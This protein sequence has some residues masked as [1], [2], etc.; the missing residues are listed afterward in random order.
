M[1]AGPDTLDTGQWL[2]SVGTA[3]A[4][5]EVGPIAVVKYLVS[6][7]MEQTFARER[8]FAVHPLLENPTGARIVWRDQPEP[9]KLFFFSAAVRDRFVACFAVADLLDL[10]PPPMQVLLVSWRSVQLPS[11]E[12]CVPGTSL[13]L[14]QRMFGCLPEA[15]A[16]VVVL[17]LQ[18]VAQAALPLDDPFVDSKG[19][20]AEMY[21][22]TL[23]QMVTTN[24]V[25]ALL[26]V[27]FLTKRDSTLVRRMSLFS[28]STALGRRGWQCGYT[29][30]W[31]RSCWPAT[32]V[33]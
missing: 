27:V 2:Q 17:A 14:A 4:L 24:C 28:V 3:L 12:T 15:G 18:D 16:G 25:R 31:R 33:R 5:V 9:L 23:F 8:I 13:A 7:K 22:V 32:L 11:T 10:S 21:V 1:G 30:A 26:L 6:H 20:S 29:R 19:L